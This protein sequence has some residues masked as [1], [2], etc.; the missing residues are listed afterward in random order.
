MYTIPRFNFT[1]HT[2]NIFEIFF[3]INWRI[4]IT[5][6]LSVYNFSIY[7]KGCVIKIMFIKCL[8]NERN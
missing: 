3:I 2:I 4:V 1:L 7:T 8:H 5:L 6:M